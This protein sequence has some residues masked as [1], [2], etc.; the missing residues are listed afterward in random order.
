MAAI[1]G[2]KTQLIARRRNRRPLLLFPGLQT[3][4]MPPFHHNLSRLYR[5]LAQ[6]F[7]RNPLYDWSLGQRSSGELAVCK[8]I[9]WPDDR[10]SGTRLLADEFR[11]GSEIVRHPNP[12]GRPLG[13]SQAWLAYLNGFSWLD[14][15]RA[16]S[17]P[18][19]KTKAR[20]IV[21]AWLAEHPR[22]DCLAWRADILGDRLHRL[23]VNHDFLQANGDAM[24]RARLLHALNRQARHLARVLPDGRM[25]ADP[26]RGAIALILAGALLP[27]GGA[28]DKAGR[29]LFQRQVSAQILPDGG[30]VER[31]PGVMLDLL[32]RLLDLRVALGAT[33]GTMPN[34]LGATISGLAGAVRMLCHGDGG[35]ATFNDTIEGDSALARQCL[36]EAGEFPRDLVELP[37]TGFQRLEAGKS[38]IIQDCGRPPPPGLDTHAHAGT[39][40]FEFSHAGQRIIVNCGAHPNSREWRGVQRN[41]A[42]H[43]TLIV[44]DTNSSMLLPMAGTGGGGM[45]L[46]P[47][48]LTCRRDET[49]NGTLV[50]ASH[51]GYS[52]S[53]GLVHVRRL[54]LTGDG[55]ELAG[56]D[57][58]LG[59]S[60]GAFALRFHLHPDVQSVVTQNGQAA[61]LKPTGGAGWRLRLQGGDLALADSVYLAGNGQIRRAQQLVVL[62]LVQ[63]ERT[64]V[65]WSLQREVARR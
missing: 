29:K 48:V 27:D 8:A 42:A 18:A 44:D 47:A 62:G 37:A 20:Q 46:R 61:L 16:L 53:F 12:L 6:P 13:A 59:E 39:L 32:R 4:L 11:H 28:F 38:V 63:G 35:L 55:S 7:Y 10:E 24:F 15:L 34:D 64:R 40:S 2:A 25:G 43:S 36:V 30:H 50:E 17:G 9:D 1:P 65:K 23:L 5:G 56:E 14:Q 21:E 26:L 31:S 19:A 58:L 60:G 45:A 22:Y 3:A 52:D 57:H 33:S 54:L 41:T 51:D 49:P